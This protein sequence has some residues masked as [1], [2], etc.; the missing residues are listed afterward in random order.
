[1]TPKVKEKQ[2]DTLIMPNDVQSNNK[3]VLI[4]EIN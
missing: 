4:Q 2:R 3:N 1:L